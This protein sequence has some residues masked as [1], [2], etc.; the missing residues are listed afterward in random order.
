M[1]KQVLLSSAL[2]QALHFRAHPMI[3]SFEFVHAS[4][5]R[6]VTS[7][8]HYSIAAPTAPV[9]RRMCYEFLRYHKTSIFR[10][11]SPL[12]FPNPWSMLEER[13][14]RCRWARRGWQGDCLRWDKDIR[15]RRPGSLDTSTSVPVPKC[16]QKLTNN[17][18]SQS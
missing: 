11:Q 6:Q 15:Y 18:S 3:P 14:S 17:L 2:P 5:Q 7:I 8:V 4:P 13:S 10:P 12:P 1:W 9:L 16:P